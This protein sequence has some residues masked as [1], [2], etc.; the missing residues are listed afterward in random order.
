M[1]SVVYSLIKET[2]SEVCCGANKINKNTQK[3]K[4]HIFDYKI[5]F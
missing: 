5:F 2:K 4:W 1:G 3:Y